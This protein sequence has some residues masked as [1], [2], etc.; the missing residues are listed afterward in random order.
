M[1]K[2]QPIWLSGC[3]KNSHFI[4]KK[5]KMHEI[6]RENKVEW[7]GMRHLLGASPRL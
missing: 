4:A 5:L 3:P 1:D 7:F 2:A 6:T